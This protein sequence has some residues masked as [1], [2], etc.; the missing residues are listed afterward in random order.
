[1][2]I[3]VS[4]RRSSSPWPRGRAAP[5]SGPAYLSLLRTAHT[6]LPLPKA[7]IAFLATL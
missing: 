1:M 4:F 6:S 3:P 7:I 2:D 5:W